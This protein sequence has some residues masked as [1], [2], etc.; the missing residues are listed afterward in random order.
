MYL[1]THYSCLVDN[2]WMTTCFK[3]HPQTP[4]P[5]SHCLPL[6]GSE[7]ILPILCLYF[8]MSIMKRLQVPWVWL[9]C[10]SARTLPRFFFL[11]E[12]SFHLLSSCHLTLTQTFGHTWND[13]FSGKLYSVICWVPLL[14]WHILLASLHHNAL[15]TFLATRL[16]DY[17]IFI[18]GPAEPSTELLT[19]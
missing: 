7:R 13:A 19:H 10:P 6:L 8:P 5:C 16:G 9:L 17:S 18:S 14:E 11:L 15:F 4:V 1:C 3:N 12:C 2:L